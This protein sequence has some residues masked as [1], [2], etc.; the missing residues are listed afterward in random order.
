MKILFAS[1]VLWAFVVGYAPTKIAFDGFVQ[2]SAL[3][4]T[5]GATK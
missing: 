5:I 4:Q 1:L 2:T 3:V